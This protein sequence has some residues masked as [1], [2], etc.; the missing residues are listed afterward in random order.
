MWV[1]RSIARTSARRRL[2]RSAYVA[3]AIFLRAVVL[4]GNV[5]PPGDFF[6]AEETAGSGAALGLGAGTVICNHQLGQTGRTDR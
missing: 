6:Q 1:G 5:V 4:L 2:S 3:Y